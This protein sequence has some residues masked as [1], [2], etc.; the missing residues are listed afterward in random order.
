MLHPKT[1][2]DLKYFFLNNPQATEQKLQEALT[3]TSQVHI[4]YDVSYDKENLTIGFKNGTRI[5]ITPE[6]NDYYLLSVYSSDGYSS[7]CLKQASQ[8]VD[9]ILKTVEKVNESPDTVR[10]NDAFKLMH[11]LKMNYDD[12]LDIVSRTT[13][14]QF[15]KYSKIFNMQREV[16]TIFLL[17]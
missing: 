9:E 17:Q 2:G 15:D 3:N 10:E 11:C 7:C 4:N 6:S 16:Q 5:E 12:A 8:N 1:I 14:C 13:D